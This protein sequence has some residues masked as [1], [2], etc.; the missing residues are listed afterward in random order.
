M[1][2]IDI[3]MGDISRQEVDILVSSASPDLDGT[4]G[5][6]RALQ[7]RG[8]AS[9]LDEYKAMRRSRLADGRP[10]SGLT[11]TSAGR[12]RAKWVIHVTAPEADG[13]DVAE[14]LLRCYR[15]ALRC[16]EVLQAR[17]VAL[18]A[19]GAGGAGIP[20]ETVA[21]SAIKAARERAFP[22]RVAFVLFN[23]ETFRA[24]IDA[25]TG[26]VGTNECTSLK[27]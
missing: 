16:A 19:V 5:V 17:S 24:F 12:L 6:E 4:A 20:V 10:P 8:G 21:S 14:R 13:Y 2:R 26:T 1:A 15:D 23:H 7:L 18:P 3:T 11:V 25:F 22:F 27:G 9:I